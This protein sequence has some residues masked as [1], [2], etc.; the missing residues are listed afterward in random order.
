MLEAATAL[1]AHMPRS[2]LAILGVTIG[3]AAV[4]AVLALMQALSQSIARQYHGLGG[5]MVTIRAYTPLEDVFRGKMNR[6]RTQDLEHL[7]LRIGSIANI[8]PVIS[9]AGRPQIEA[10][11]GTHT[12]MAMVLGTTHGFQEVH[13]TFVSTGRF[14]AH[15]DNVTRRRVA[16][17]GDGLREALRLP[18]EKVGNY[19]QLGGEWF[20]VVGHMPRRANLLGESEDNHVLIPYETALAMGDHTAQPDLSISFTLPSGSVRTSTLAEVTVLLRKLHRLE[21][22]VPSDFIIETPESLQK[23]FDDLVLAAS[24]VAAGV[25]GVSLLVG[26]VG[27]AN[28][29]FLSVQER[30][31][32]IAVAKALGAP[33]QFILAQFLAEATFLSLVGALTGLLVGSVIGRVVA[34][35]IPDLPSP[36][37]HWGIYAGVILF[38]TLIGALSGFLPAR[39]AARLNVAEVLRKE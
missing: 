1:R 13:Q 6:L 28:L 7:K 32:E 37:L 18:R 38:C 2:A 17:L 35:L 39:K 29:M 21:P 5:Q 20:R 34:A 16:V 33:P 3:V 23:S 9:P 4:I 14:V 26:G 19:I 31:Q 25:V 22:G 8:T 27:I 11:N 24:L 12:S 10:R 15:T 36:S 30:A